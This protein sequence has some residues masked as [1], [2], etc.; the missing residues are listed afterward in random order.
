MFTVLCHIHPPIM[1]KQ[2]IEL[3][4]DVHVGWL[5]LDYPALRAD[6]GKDQEEKDLAMG[7]H[8]HQ[9]RKDLKQVKNLKL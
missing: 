8:S 9:V 6:D 3:L 7:A 1:A 4:K 2:S 5:P